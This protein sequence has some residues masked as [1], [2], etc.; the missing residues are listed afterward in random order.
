MSIFTLKIIACITMILDHIKYAIPSTN[1][2]I[3]IYFGRIAFPLFAFLITEGYVHTN[4]L[5]RY[6]KR[7]AIFAL[8]SQIPFMLFRTLVGEWLM[9]NI[10]F[11]FLLGLLA[12]GVFD[13]IKNKII[14]IPICLVIIGL[15]E[16]LRVDYGWFGVATVLIFYIFKQSRIWQVIMFSVLVAIYYYSKGI[17]NFITTKI[18]LFYLFT[19][20]PAFLICL[21]NGKLGRK[22]KYFFYWFY[23][24]HLLIFYFVK[25]C[26]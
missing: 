23:P 8:I 26:F 22:M 16:I 3:T 24:V 19:I 6:V 21:Y 9:L 10:M 14:S 17:F 5:E 11:T 4:S 20:L 2:I 15:G 1:G 25:F 7:L 13:K 18:L 12:I